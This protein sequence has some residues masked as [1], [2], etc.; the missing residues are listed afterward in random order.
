MRLI[1]AVFIGSRLL[2][3]LLAAS[4]TL[5]RA[6]PCAGKVLEYVQEWRKTASM[7]AHGV[8][9]ST[10]P[11]ETKL[12]EFLRGRAEGPIY[13]GGE[14]RVHTQPDVQ[15]SR[16]LKQWFPNRIQ[17]FANGVDFLIAAQEQYSKIPGISGRLEVVRIYE[18]GPDWIVR[19][20]RAHTRPLK[21][22][23]GNDLVARQTWQEL[24][25]LANSHQARGGAVQ[26]LQRMLMANPVSINLHWDPQAR[27]VLMIDGF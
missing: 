16:A 22:V 1:P 6:G 23:I 25:R 9:V 13:E 15:H 11:F 8:Q 7:E 12:K 10:L 3:L 26:R 2:A 19:E 21:D 27:K 14:G 17:D 18:R 4:P 20:F 24:R 5:A